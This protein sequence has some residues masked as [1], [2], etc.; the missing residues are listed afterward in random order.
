LAKTG[1][2]LINLGTPNSPSVSDVRAYLNEFLMD[3]YVLDTPWLLRRLIVSAFI[4]PTRPKQSAHAYASIWGEHESPLLTFSRALS[5]ALE[6]S[7]A[8]PVALAMRYGSPSIGDAITSLCAAGVD[9]VVITPLYP[10]YADST[11]TTSVEAA[12][13]KMPE[14]VSASVLPPFYD[15]KAYIDALAATVRDALPDQW[16]HLLMSYH[17]LPE[18]HLTR[19][20]PTGSHCLSDE[21]CCETP[22]SAHATCYRH[23]VLA[24]S[25]ALCNALSLEAN[26]YSVSFQSRLG[27]LPW[28]RPYT[29]Q[30][31]AEL[32][33]E[34]V[35]HL[36]VV[37]PAFVA[38]N[39]E[40]LE[41]IGIQGRETFLAAGGE[42]LTLI[43][44]LNDSPAW[45]DAL[46]Q[47]LA[48]HTS[49]ANADN[50]A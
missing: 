31:L 2:L 19:T 50:A 5:D 40:T 46:A 12:R 27:R 39:L 32:A 11:V 44:C 7:L 16:D 14:G 43:P 48:R 3:P 15:D 25:R 34:G 13:A 41:E 21:H 26:R 29:D 36:A 49:S 42:S 9:H 18:R 47:A 38:D 6:A 17:G 8:A 10:H 4:L 1:Y 35:K 28:L 30:R 24:T 33:Q 23:Q 45:I 20:D 37:C 22:S